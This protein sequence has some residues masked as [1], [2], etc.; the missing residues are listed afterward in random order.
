VCE[1]GKFRSSFRD[2]CIAAG[3]GVTGGGGV[4]GGRGRQVEEVPDD[5]AVV[6]RTADDLEVI[7]LETKN[8]ARVLDEGS[9]AETSGRCSGVQRCGQVPD[10]Y[11]P[12]V[13]SADDAFVVEAD[14]TN[15]FLVTF[16][17]PQT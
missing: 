17:Y 3:G 15:Q 13:C 9:E 1:S 8:A 7:E 2:V 12:V 5:D 11:L 16:Q 6:V 14:A 4:C 10:L